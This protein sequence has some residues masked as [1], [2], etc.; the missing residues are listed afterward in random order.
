MELAKI[1][2]SA[3]SDLPS[4][5]ET[6][7]KQFIAETH[8]DGHPVGGYEDRLFN[9]NHL[10][11]NFDVAWDVDTINA[12]PEKFFSQVRTGEGVELF[13]DQY[14]VMCSSA[15][16]DVDDKIDVFE[17][18]EGSPLSCSV[19]RVRRMGL[20]VVTGRWKIPGRP[21]GVVMDIHS[22]AWAYDRYK[23]ELD[24]YNQICIPDDDH[25]RQVLI[26]GYMVSQFLADFKYELNFSSKMEYRQSNI[27]IYFHHWY[28]LIGLVFLQFWENA[29]RSTTVYYSHDRP[30]PKLQRKSSDMQ[31]S[32]V[33]HSY[34]GPHLALMR[35]V[36]KL[37]EAYAAIMDNLKLREEIWNELDEDWTVSS[38]SYLLLLMFLS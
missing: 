20:R 26:F 29:M 15:F 27:V 33:S 21:L 24:A 35:R 10:Q 18:A 38:L 11:W 31:Q 34:E 6:A 1:D 14:V 28:S 2:K 16:E 7:L 9:S 19:E 17:F 32:I 25:S 37:E 8:P 23:H 3:S 36:T 22:G 13:G 5:L 12:D 30:V 4:E